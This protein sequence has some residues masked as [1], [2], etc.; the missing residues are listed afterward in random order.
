MDLSSRYTK[1]NGI[2]SAELSLD[3]GAY[4]KDIPCWNG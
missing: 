3:F 2:I 4:V 1:Q